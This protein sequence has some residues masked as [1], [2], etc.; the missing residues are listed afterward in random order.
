MASS[1]TTYSYFLKFADKALVWANVTKLI[2]FGLDVQTVSVPQA[3]TISAPSGTITDTSAPAIVWVHV[4]VLNATVTTKA[5]TSNVATITTSAAHGFLVG[6]DVTVNLTTPDAVFDGTYKITAVTSTTFSYARTNANVGSVG[7][8]GTASIGDGAPQIGYQVYVYSAAQYGAGGF[9]AGTSAATW[10]SSGAGLTSVIPTGLVNGTTYRAYVRTA[11]AAG[12][13]SAWS[14]FAFST[15]TPSIA[16][17]IVTLAASF[18][19]ANNRVQLTYAGS[20]NLLTA[21]EANAETTVGT[22]TALTNA[23]APTRTT[24]QAAAGVASVLMSSTAAGTMDVV[25]STGLN[26]NPVIVGVAYSAIASFRAAVSVRTVGIKIRWY[27]AA[28]AFLSDSTISTAGTAE[29]TSAWVTRSTTA[30]APASAAFGAVVAEVQATAAG[31]EQHYVDLIALHPGSTPAY[32]PGGLTF[33][34]AITRT[35]AGGSTTDVRPP[36]TLDAAQ[37][38]TLYDYEAI[39][40]VLTTYSATLVASGTAGTLTSAAATATATATNDGT[41]WLKAVSTPA[42]N[43]GAV[44]VLQNPAEATAENLGVF[45]LDGRTDTV[46][47]SGQ[48]FGDDIDFAIATSTAADFEAVKALVTAQSTLLLQEPFIDSTGVGLQRWIRIIDRSW[49]KEGVPTAPR[50]IFTVRAVETGKGY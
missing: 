5:L 34:A 19:S 3:P 48:M 41:W 35:P 29:S 14:A 44:R 4:D 25:T 24:A 22:W 10:S 7:A 12:T 26:A 2:E 16:L 20:G 8:P 11:K 38:A 31:A 37:R 42:L 13:G 18:D 32:S 6:N 43:K 40:G 46:V 27:D 15:F 33:T 17:P 28:G 23:A 45:R 50:R 21:D 9:V 36:L 30:T 1:S 49:T 39:R 47:V